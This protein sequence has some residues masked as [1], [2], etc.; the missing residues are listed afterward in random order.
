[1]TNDRKNGASSRNRFPPVWS[2]PSQLKATGPGASK[3]QRSPFLPPLAPGGPGAPWPLAAS[4]G[5]CLCPSASC[6]LSLVS[7]PLIRSQS[8][9]RACPDLGGPGLQGPIK[10]PGPGPFVVKDTGAGPGRRPAPGVPPLRRTR[11]S[12][13]A[14]KAA[15]DSAHRPSV[16]DPRAL[17]PGTPRLLGPHP[18]RLP[19]PTSSCCRGDGP[20]LGGRGRGA[21]CDCFTPPTGGVGGGRRQG[22]RPAPPA[23][24]QRQPP[25]P[26]EPLSRRPPSWLCSARRGW[27][28]GVPAFAQGPGEAGAA[29]L[30]PGP[31]EMPPGPVRGTH[32]RLRRL[33]LEE[34]GPRKTAPWQ[35]RPAPLL[36]SGRA[37]G[38][39]GFQQEGLGAAPVPPAEAVPGGWGRGGSACPTRARETQGAA[40]AGPGHRAVS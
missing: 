15:L 2:R 21:P 27:V 12:R 30:V 10:V 5:L 3:G 16:G 9:V 38:R 7:V 24:A 22:E 29:A 4:L 39:A 31:L 8:L 37:W 20:G 19:P 35:R 40:P 33:R 17:A 34:L 1:M 14:R 11:V 26:G 36:C 13:S 23:L 32:Q 18:Q 28:R 6:G 25:T